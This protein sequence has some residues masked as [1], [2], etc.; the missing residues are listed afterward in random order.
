MKKISLALML[1]W[2]IF[3]TGCNGSSGDNDDNG[4]GTNTSSPSLSSELLLNGIAVSQFKADETV[5]VTS[6]LLDGNN[7]PLV[8]KIISY[9]AEVGTLA[10]VSALTDDK[11]IATVSLTGN[12]VLGA[13]V[14]TATYTDTD[15]GSQSN[16]LNYE[17]IAADSVISDGAVRIG[18]FDDSN[19]FIEGEIKLT[20]ADNSVSAGG[21][22]GLTVDL[23]DEN[24][25]LITEPTPVLFTS[26]CVEN[27]KATIESQ[28]V[29]SN[30][31]ANAT[32]EDVSCAGLTGTDDLLIASITS[33]GTTN[34]ASQSIHISG[35]QLGSIAF[36]SAEPSSI[37]L[38]GSGGVDKQEFST[39]TF[40]VNS[41]LGNPLAQQEVDFSLNTDVGDI[42]LTPTSGFTNSQGE[43]STQVNAGTVPTSV[44]VT[45]KATMDFEGQATP[46]QSQSDLLSIVSDLPEQSSFTI[47]ASVLNPEADTTNGVTSTISVWLADNFNNPVP[48][49]TTVTFTAEGG[50]IPGSCNTSNGSCFVTWISANDR[51]DDHRVTILATALGHETFYETNGNNTFDDNDGNAITDTGVDSGFGSHGSEALGFIDMS[52]AWRDDNEDSVYNDGEI[53]YDDDNSDAFSAADSL[54]NG[55][56]CE[57]SSCSEQRSI[58]LRKA[59]ILIMS[60][61]DADYDLTDGADTLFADQSGAGDGLP[62][63]S[64][65]SSQS[66]RFSFTDSAGQAMPMNTS[67][68]VSSS[69]GEI[70][71]TT[72]LTMP[73]TTIPRSLDFVIVN[74]SG[75]DSE[76]GVLTITVTTPN[77]KVTS[78]VQSFNL[79]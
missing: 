34:T 69:A 50:H 70:E 35:E 16:S 33:N 21:T 53:Y 12:A 41:D 22:L 38:K 65:G 71:G 13:G 45:A 57:G 18:Y 63:I 4:S 6:V 51:V 47:A 28:V 24:D 42:S 77:N 73:N 58:R 27:A 23:V 7:Q 3:L 68:S 62:D 78:F 14:L 15:T 54:Y 64:D 37:A 56:R 2:L 59:M 1:S 5:Q 55:P 75:G 61:S 8:R 52:E 31:R 74:A 72:S 49:G 44:R 46:V 26:S 40:R 48:D 60:G 10:A 11:G 66:F 67:V 79:L 43:I 39:L 19:T 20:L 32:F 17:I 29:S 25:V 9:S 30:G 76:T 36:I